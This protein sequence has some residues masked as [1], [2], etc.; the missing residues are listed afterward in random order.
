MKEE[1]KPLVLSCLLLQCPDFADEISDLQ[2]LAAKLIAEVRV[3]TIEL[4]PERHC[5]MAGEG[6][7]T[8]A[9]LTQTAARLMVSSIL[10]K[11]S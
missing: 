7:Q 6:S 9:R 2:H 8:A 4:A 5:A 1:I 10:W 3:I 11:V